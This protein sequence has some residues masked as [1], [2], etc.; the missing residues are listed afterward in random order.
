MES[1]LN[2]YINIKSYFTKTIKNPLFD[3]KYISYDKYNSF[4]LLTKPYIKNIELNFNDQYINKTLYNNEKKK[5]FLYTVPFELFCKLNTSGISNVIDDKT[6]EEFNIFKYTLKQENQVLILLDVDI[7]D[8]LIIF[9]D[10]KKY[11][12]TDL[13]K[14]NNINIQLRLTK[15]LHYVIQKLSNINFCITNVY[16]KNYNIIFN[17]RIFNL[18]LSKTISKD[19][20]D[21]IKYYQHTIKHEEYVNLSTNRIDDK[22][23]I[24]RSTLVDREFVEKLLYSM[25]NSNKFLLFCY[26]LT[27]YNYCYYVI[28]N[29][30]I[31][32][33]MNIYIYTYHEWF[34]YIITFTWIILLY[35]E[36][37]TDEIKINNDII[38]DIE[39]A[40]LLPIYDY[41]NNVTN[42]NPYL[43]LL[44]NRSNISNKYNG[45]Q[46]ILYDYLY[47]CRT[48]P[49]CSLKEFI[50]RLN[51]FSCGSSNINIFENINFK[52]LGVV[53]TGSCMTACIQTYHPLM[54]ILSKDNYF[55]FTDDLFLRYLNEFYSS[56]DIDV[57][58]NKS[59]NE[60]FFIKVK[61]FYEKIKCNLCKY[62]L[63]TKPVLKSIKLP[64]IYVTTQF[65]KDKITIPI[66]IINKYK[67]QI[68]NEIE[69]IKFIKDNIH[70]NDIRVLFE[71]YYFDLIDTSYIE[72]SDTIDKSILEQKM[73]LFPEIYN[74]RDL[75]KKLYYPIYILE[76]TNVDIKLNINYKFKLEYMN[77]KSMDIFKI[78]NLD[79]MTSV[80]RFHL[81]CVRA[82]YDNSTV[83][84]TP[85]FISSHMTY[86]NI[87]YKY[88]MAEKDPFEIANKYRYRGY[89]IILNQTELRYIEMYNNINEKWKKYYK[90]CNNTYT[91][92]NSLFYRQNKNIT[93]YNYHTTATVYNNCD[94]IINYNNL[95]SIDSNGELPNTIRLDIAEILAKN[96]K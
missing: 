42:N 22:S 31:L 10:D 52:S 67:I 70:E 86:E 54:K 83:Y 15:S 6:L 18:Q 23:F 47:L 1:T 90:S 40:N 96:I 35:T 95:L 19:I 56:A 13:H 43:P 57:M 30:N 27:S 37:Q 65:I 17:K 32:K 36:N 75:D 41:K 4:V 38:F 3:K 39:T 71:P 51:L 12:L 80:A 69:K 60:Y 28:N 76:N 63:D 24:I 21:F 93:Y 74:N 49:I 44:I 16:A 59:T 73:Y 9:E 45:V 94:D 72:Y 55:N 78:E 46:N 2:L 68:T 81:P 87:D 53:I 66:D 62:N 29:K 48:N 25:S 79:H 26:L 88:F 8:M 85:S 64:K 84:M 14:F 92:I 89:G 82:L 7:R 5:I 77:T 58:F 91:D 33:M 34:R 20:I 61:Q 11:T 50:I